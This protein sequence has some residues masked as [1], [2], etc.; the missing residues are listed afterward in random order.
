MVGSFCKV[1]QIEGAD[2]LSGIIVPCNLQRLIKQFKFGQS[3]CKQQLDSSIALK[4][5]LSVIPTVVQVYYKEK[6]LCVCVCLYVCLFVPPGSLRL[7]SG[8]SA[9]AQWLQGV[10]CSCWRCAAC[11]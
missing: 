3:C 8:W 11:Y 1:I 7:Q 5:P 2:Q 6:R 4:Y 9:D 10:V